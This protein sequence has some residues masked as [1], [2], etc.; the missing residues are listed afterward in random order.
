MTFLW[1]GW[2]C[3]FWGGQPQWQSAISYSIISINM[4]STN[5]TGGDLQNTLIST[6]QNWQGHQ[7]NKENLRQPRRA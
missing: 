5:P 1:L 3:Q 7:K 2:D 4:A 6:P